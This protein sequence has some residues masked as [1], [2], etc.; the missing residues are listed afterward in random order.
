MAA[1]AAA[2]REETGATAQLMSMRQIDV[3]QVARIEIG[4]EAVEQAFADGRAMTLDE[5]IEYARTLASS[6]TDHETGTSRA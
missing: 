1:A 3:T 5:A 2:L 4:E 6:R